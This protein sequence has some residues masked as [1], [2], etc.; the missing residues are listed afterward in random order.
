MAICKVCAR[1][2]VVMV[3]VSGVG[4]PK[5]RAEFGLCEAHTCLAEQVGKLGED[6]AMRESV[7]VGQAFIAALAEGWAKR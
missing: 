3:S 2:A 1:A 4:A 6:R 7:K 5:G